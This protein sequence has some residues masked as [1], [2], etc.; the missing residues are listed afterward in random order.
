M[1]LALKKIRTDGETQA[2]TQLSKATIA[3]YAEAM[4]AGADFPPVDVFKDK[5]GDHWL[6][7]G[8]HRYFAAERAELKSI[9]VVLHHGDRRAARLFSLGANSQHGLKRTNEDKRNSVMG[10]LTDAEWCK[11]TD[12]RIANHC[13]VAQPFVSKLREEASDNGY[14][15]PEVRTA[16]RNGK[17]Y[18]VKVPPRKEKAAEPEP[19]PP[20]D[21]EVIHLQVNDSDVDAL[22]DMPLS[23]VNS[24]RGEDEVTCPE[25]L[26]RIE[27]G[28]SMG[29]DDAPPDAPEPPLP[30]QAARYDRSPNPR[31]L[32]PRLADAFHAMFDQVESIA[33]ILNTAK[34]AWADLQDLVTEL[35]KKGELPA[36]VDP[37]RLFGAGALNVMMHLGEY[38]VVVRAA[39][40]RSL[41]PTCSGEA[42]TCETCA[43]V[44]WLPE[45]RAKTE[46]RTAAVAGGVR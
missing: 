21:D 12:H 20:P 30:R 8:F 38:A 2:R 36:N 7:D 19:P 18:E 35:A 22:C 3:E 13:G 15:M 28:Y 4:E 6:A 34:A 25:C 10:M 41:C 42:D 17:E 23:T 27:D 33:S 29:D 1:Q 44:G 46:E 37:V 32:P 40:P 24:T 16:V 43:G 11:W 9:G 26:R 45:Y 14:Q 5:G 39:R 31:A